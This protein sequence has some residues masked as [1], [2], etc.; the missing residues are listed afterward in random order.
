MV[1]FTMERL[2]TQQVLIPLGSVPQQSQ[3]GNEVLT[4]PWRDT[5]LQS[6]LEVEENEFDASEEW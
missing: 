3:F 6:K 5:D 1:I 2:R 4:N